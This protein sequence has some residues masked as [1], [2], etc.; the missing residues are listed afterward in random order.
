MC[1]DTSRTT[2][3]YTSVPGKCVAIEYYG[4]SEQER[5]K[6]IYDLDADGYMDEG[7]YKQY[8]AVP[9]AFET[10][11]NEVYITKRDKDAAGN[12]TSTR[13][14]QITLFCVQGIWDDNDNYVCQRY[15][16]NVNC[17]YTKQDISYY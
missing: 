5:I 9:N 11:P 13:T 16:K 15:M 3:D 6:T 10:N 8:E 2:Y 4:S 14:L 7:N 1:G 17:Y 12:T